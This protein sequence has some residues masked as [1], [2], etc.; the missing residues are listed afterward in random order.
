MTAEEKVARQRVSVLG[1]AEAL[2]NVAEARQCRGVVNVCQVR[3]VV[4]TS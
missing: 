1:L 4:G 3:K 2:G